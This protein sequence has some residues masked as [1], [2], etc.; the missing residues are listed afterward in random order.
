VAL[1]DDSPLVRQ[2]GRETAA[3]ILQGYGGASR[4]GPS[5]AEQLDARLAEVRQGDVT[6]ESREEARRLSEHL[7]AVK[8]EERRRSGALRPGEVP[9]GPLFGGRRAPMPPTP[10]MR[11]T[12]VT[13]T[14]DHLQR[15]D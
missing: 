4:Q 6:A 5:T 7:A 1:T 2:Y 11:R 8:R 15:G 13:S 14:G 10:G 3:R 9:A 12:V